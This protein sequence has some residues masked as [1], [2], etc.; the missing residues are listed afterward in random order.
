MCIYLYRYLFKANFHWTKNVTIYV[1]PVAYVYV[2]HGKTAYIYLSILLIIIYL[3]IY[4]LIGILRL[5]TTRVYR[6]RWTGRKFVG[7]W[8]KILDIARFEMFMRVSITDI[9]YYTYTLYI[10]YTCKFFLYSKHILLFKY[11]VC[12]T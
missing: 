1:T 5:P 9:L 7:R 11:N 3:Y 4:S 12:L 10:V 8:N 2:I 6:S